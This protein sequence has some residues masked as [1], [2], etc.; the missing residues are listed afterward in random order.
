MYS[1]AWKS[2]FV[3]V[4]HHGYGGGADNYIY[5]V[6]K[7]QMVLWPVDAARATAGSLTTVTHNK[8]FT[9]NGK[10]NGVTYHMASG[11]SVTILQFANGTPTLTFYSTFS[12]FKAS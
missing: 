10:A 4:T 9:T 12:K 5:G 2:D 11:S 6:I 7:P 1:K 8:Y 3:Q